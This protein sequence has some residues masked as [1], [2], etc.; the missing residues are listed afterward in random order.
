MAVLSN[1]SVYLGNLI[2]SYNSAVNNNRRRAEDL[3]DT[4]TKILNDYSLFNIYGR[5]GVYTVSLVYYQD[6]LT[7][8][9]V[10]SENDAWDV[11]ISDLQTFFGGIHPLN[12]QAFQTATFANPLTI[13]V[14]TYKNWRCTVTGSTEITLT[15]HGSGDNGQIILV[16]DNTG[17]YAVTL[18]SDV[19][20]LGYG[21]TGVSTIANTYNLLTWTYDGTD[22]HYTLSNTTALA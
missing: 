18:D 14:T 16:I 9:E 7:I 4:I 11:T 2:T 1:F 21:T 5:D 10:D 3:A 22:V 8:M 17:G 15:G 12:N 19:F 6:M 13:D 20:T